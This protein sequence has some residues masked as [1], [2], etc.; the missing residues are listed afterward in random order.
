MNTLE[1]ALEYA[2]MG[3]AVI[4]V[5]ERS[6]APVCRNGASD[7]TT[8]EAQIREWWGE[9]PNYNI[10]IVCN[11][12]FVID[13][14]TLK[15]GD[16][17]KGIMSGTDAF[18]LFCADYPS[19]PVTGP[20]SITGGGGQH[21]LFAKPSLSIKA[22]TKVKYKGIQTAVDFRVGNSYIVAPPSI[23]ENGRRY[24]WKQP[25]VRVSDLP[26]LPE[27]F[28]RQICQDNG[29]L[30]RE[31]Q[32]APPSVWEPCGLASVG[33]PDA[34]E[35]CRM[36]VSRIPGAVSGEGGHKQ[37]ISVANA[38]FYDFG[39]SEADGWPILTE[40]N[41]RCEPPWSDGELR[42]KMTEA[43]RYQHPE[44]KPQGWKLQEERETKQSD[45][46][47]LTRQ[48]DKPGQAVAPAMAG[49]EEQEKQGR[50]LLGVCA[51]D[52]DIQSPSWLWEDHILSGEITI[53]AG[54]GGS[55]KTTLAAAIAAQ[56][57]A[58]GE[59]PDGQP[60]ERGEV[61]Y[62]DVENNLYNTLVPR[63]L[64]AGGDDTR[65]LFRQFIGEGTRKK[66]FTLDDMD[67]LE[68]EL[69]ERPNIKLIVFDPITT[70]V[71][72]ENDNNNAVVRAALL[73]LSDVLH[74]Y[75]VACIGI[76]HLRKGFAENMFAA[77]IVSGASAFVNV[78]RAVYTLFADKETDQ[79][80]ALVA[81]WNIGRAPAGLAFDI[82]EKTLTDKNGNELDPIGY[83][84][85]TD[86][87]LDENA[88]E[89]LDKLKAKAKLNPE[90]VT[91]QQECA[92]WLAE[93]LQD[94]PAIAFATKSGKGLVAIAE[95]S[96]FSRRTLGRVVDNDP[97]FEA[98]VGSDRMKYVS[99][100][101][102]KESQRGCPPSLND[103]KVP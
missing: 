88:N 42:H 1:Q 36:Y 52:I 53:L 19:I 21:W 28:L 49:R 41:G 18:A 45:V 62:F 23:H 75:G 17:D 10:G 77:E 32:P 101:N 8:D 24:R 95:K 50:R 100:T 14:D 98:K 7:G 51:A 57:A 37:T 70:F 54:A 59:W 67:L 55:G 34:I 22:S 47:S 12:C 40:Y 66:L 83:A 79:R 99:L 29:W 97:R 85:I 43:K 68:D 6:K 72:S 91:K 5:K 25:L 81:K 16:K 102:L 15:D 89:Y 13:L 39:L 87:D 61:L 31:I 35:R 3:Y 74:K 63:F 69:K 11:N 2:R 92:N 93:Y 46:M 20:Q 73:Q 64:A 84:E 48:T 65:L 33:R 76:H 9:N 4:P 94:R 82:V 90:R 27:D 71:A 44:G 38:I 86:W 103:T 78:P 30:S 26:E 80:K 58:G 56:V 60:C 96:G